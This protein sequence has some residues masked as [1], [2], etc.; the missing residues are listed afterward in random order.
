MSEQ[1]EEQIE[2]VIFHNHD[3]PYLGTVIFMPAKETTG[4]SNP[5]ATPPCLTNDDY[6]YD[7]QGRRIL[8]SRA[9]LKK[10]LF[11]ISPADRSLQGKNRK[12]MVVK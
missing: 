8:S 2:T 7:L 10:G 1:T 3:N 11:V 4:I 9:N 5:S 6:V 12:K